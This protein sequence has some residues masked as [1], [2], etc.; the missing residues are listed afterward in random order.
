MGAENVSLD[1]PFAR[2]RWRTLPALAAVGAVA[3]VM[4]LI[5]DWPTDLG[6]GIA[7]VTVGVATALSLLTDPRLRL[8][9]PLPMLAGFL[10]LAAGLPSYPAPELLA[11]VGGVVL[12]AWIAEDAARPSGGL[13]RGAIGWGLPCLAVG[14]AWV[15]AF[16]LPPSAAPVGVAGGL[17]AAVVIALA[18]LFHRPEIVTS[19]PAPTL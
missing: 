6:I 5:G 10:V 19:E 17:L 4:A 12:L 3:I 11:G 16:L 1:L 14:L 9:A 15:S 18:W 7:L 13:L 8:L 2:A